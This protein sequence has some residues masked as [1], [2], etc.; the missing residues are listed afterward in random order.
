MQA[1]APT[2]TPQRNIGVALGRGGLGDRS[3]NDSTNEGLQQA[4]SELGIRYRVMELTGDN[5]QLTN[6][7][8]LLT[9][10]Y[11]LIIV[12]GQE[13]VAALQEVAAANP[14]QRFA[15]LDAVVDAPN[16]T[17]ITFRE[18][19]GDFLAGA[20]SAMLSK[21][22]TVGFLGG[23][24]IPLIRRIE[25]GW[26]EGVRYIN[27]QATILTEYA[28]DVGDFSGFTKPE[29]GREL[30]LRMYD[31]QAEVIY[32]AAGRTA[33]GAIEAAQE[34]ERP[35][36][37][38]GSDQRW[39]APAVVVTSRTKNM[40]TAVLILLRDLVADTLAPGTRELDL[41]SGGIGM[42]GLDSPLIT[43]D[44]R[45]RLVAIENE[46]K[47]GTLVIKEFTTP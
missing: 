38:T 5:D 32:A 47:S 29:L 6:L 24:D 1:P 10:Q 34:I 40:N 19:E 2:A 4:Q 43:S 23:A 30:T 14:T 13:Y 41:K 33:L 11:D 45:D 37:T 22:G 3:F 42:A 15:I 46:L 9:E 39:I 20:L 26:S 36:I 31:Q 18:M 17:S 7:K 12:V 28:G 25:H 8:L 16:I 35:I 44:M 27:P 21:N